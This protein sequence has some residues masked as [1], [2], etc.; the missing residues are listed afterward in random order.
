MI[1]LY[2]GLESEVGLVCVLRRERGE[3]ILGA[4]NV[5]DRTGSRE[6]EKGENGKREW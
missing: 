3:T 5:R 4:E 1:A 2:T 6:E